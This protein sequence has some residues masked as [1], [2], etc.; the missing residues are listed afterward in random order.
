[1]SNE[2]LQ[3]LIKI[4]CAFLFS[5]LIGIEREHEHKV[6][7]LRTCVLLCLSMVFMMILNEELIVFFDAKVGLL[8]LP[9]YCVMSIGFLG[10]GIM[11]YHHGHSEGITTACVL[12]LLVS[13]GMFCGVGEYFIA[14]VN[15]LTCYIVLKLKHITQFL[16]NKHKAT[17]DI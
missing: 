10:S 9:S 8:R 5:L 3:L 6:A 17:K 1:V 13:I 2:A 4:A 12:L 7:G 14:G 16:N 11:V 15:S